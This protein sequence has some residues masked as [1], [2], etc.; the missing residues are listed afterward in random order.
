INKKAPPKKRIFEKFSVCVKN[1]TQ[2]MVDFGKVATNSQTTVFNH[3][4]RRLEFIN[5]QTI[6]FICTHPPYMAAVPYAEY[7]KLSLWWLGYCQDKL[8]KS[9]IGGRRSRDDT[10]ERY[11]DDMGVSLT[12]MK[13]VLRKEK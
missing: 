8:E 6:D 1:M 9:L 13:R 2:G 11:F 4:S 12:E 3:D 10:P 5:D 7:Q